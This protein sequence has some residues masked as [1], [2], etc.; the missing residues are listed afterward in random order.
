MLEINH[1]IYTLYENSI[2]IREIYNTFFQSDSSIIYIL[3]SSDHFAGIITSGDFMRRLR[4]GESNFIRRNCSSIIQ[5]NEEQMMKEAE[6]LFQK[7]HITTAVPV[8]DEA[9]KI[10]CEIREKREIQD[11]EFLNT[12]YGELYKYEKSRYL[13]QEV[14]ALRK[15][16]QNQF[17]TVIGTKEQFRHICGKLFGETEN[18]RYVSGFEDAYEY[19]C[20]NKNLLIDV[21]LTPYS[22]RRDLYHIGEN[23]YEWRTFF[24]KIIQM[25]RV[26]CF[27]RFYR[28]TNNPIATLKDYIE[29]YVDGAIYFSSWGI[30]T[31]ALK[32]YL[33]KNHIIAKYRGGVYR[34]ESFQYRYKG[35]GV[36]IHELVKGELLV[37]EQADVMLQYYYIYREFCNRVSVLNFVFDVDVQIP[38]GDSEP[39]VRDKLFYLNRYV[40]HIK[41]KGTN[42]SLYVDSQ[43]SVLQHLMELEA[44]LKFCVTRR[45]ENDLL[46]LRDYTSRL[47]N[48]EN[49]V[50]KTCCQPEEYVGTIYFFGMC[51]VYGALVEDCYTIPSIVQKYVNQS[52]KKYRVVNLGNEI[53]TNYLHMKDSLNICEEDIIVILF[54]FIT[55]EIKKRIPVIEIGE[56]YNRLW[57]EEFK[58]KE[59]F[60][61]AIQHCGDYG[62]LIY[63]R[64][65]YH[66]LKKYLG[67][68]EEKS[69][70]KKNIY[71]IFA[72]NESD[73]NTFYCLEDYRRKLR[74]ERKK[75]PENTQKIGS[76][77][78]NCNPFTAGHRYL[79]EYALKNVDYLF[80]F[81]VEEDKSFFTFHD[82]I[83]MVKRGTSDLSN[84][85]V[86]ESGRLIISAETF[87]TYFRKDGVIGGED[88]CLNE[89]LRIFA[90]YIAPVLNIKYRF[91]GEE[92][93]DYVTQQYNI[94]MKKILPEISGIQVIEIPRMCIGDHIVSA[95]L[96]RK[97]YHQ[98][99]FQK[100]RGLAP[101][102]TI[103]YLKKM[104]KNNLCLNTQQGVETM[105]KYVVWG[106]GGHARLLMDNFAGLENYVEVFLDTACNKSVA[107]FTVIQPDMWKDY[108]SYPVVICV[109]NSFHEVFNELIYKYHCKKE[110]IISSHEWICNLL[111]Q[112][113][114]K[115]SPKEIRLETCT[116]CQLDCPYCYMRTGDF[117]TMGRGY[118]EY[119]VFQEFIEK[120][121]QIRKIEISNNGEPFLN[122][123]LG[124]IL[125]L[126]SEKGIEITIGNGTNFNTVSD[127]I[128]ELLVKTRVS[129]VNISIDGASQEVYSMYR[130]KGDFHKVIA[131]I[132]KLNELKEK[133]HSQYPVLQWQYVLMQHNECDVEKASVM[134]KELGMNLYYKYECV[135]GRFEPEDR[136]KLERITGLNCFSVEEYNGNH[137]STYGTEMCFGTIF[138]PQINYDGRL[139][140]CCM[141]WNEDFGI[142]VFEEGLVDALN[143]EKYLKMIRILL[144]IEQDYKST[145]DIP[146]LHCQMCGRN[147]LNKK[148]LY[149]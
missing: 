114:I 115:L 116:L 99:D 82:R 139:L 92:P 12:F 4:K 113:K 3:D 69:L 87:P 126:A 89:D 78:M 75:I 130:R 52:G 23:G 66:Y 77:V 103:E 91:V 17:V 117:G 125:S 64:I 47:V 40:S 84:I 107:D 8:L 16:L 71:D 111:A 132:K 19:M 112:H 49:G 7:Y 109:K 128:L 143:S 34:E 38:E 56:D 146:C 145:E 131:N 35:N 5:K 68:T 105:Q 138:Y 15:L 79:I 27:S 118:L 54:P 73:L 95:S 133:Y 33:D 136:E 42:I 98:R 129:Y 108:E 39:I 80:V 61:D 11:E 85:S 94:A 13:G 59:A 63:S 88:V 148:F 18:I 119:G 135:H 31:F 50:R 121:P 134:A 48:V 106:A 72:L 29:K 101:D 122:P 32:E 26:E 30:L 57:R 45:F 51:T 74:K 127:E 43:D 9:G 21:S 70:K 6:E 124:K 67:R 1:K 120:N 25:I 2:L 44:S 46:V 55:E 60:M 10:C 142:N 28:V 86:V 58:Y 41:E 144:G 20:D 100:M 81:V 76:I 123:D 37:L 141:L 147:L 149:L 22:G 62:N 110:N 97:Y 83:E 90:Q 24:N 104:S 65:I 140:G 102:T 96:V 14:A 36:L 137:E 93:S 53:P